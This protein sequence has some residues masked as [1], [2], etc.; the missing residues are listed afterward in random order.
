LSAQIQYALEAAERSG[1]ETRLVEE[2]RNAEPDVAPEVMRILERTSS[3]RVRNAAALALADMRAEGARDSLIEAL[4][5]VETR[6]YR[7]TILYALD[8]L[9]ANLP[10]SVVI[11][12]IVDDPYEAREEAL[13]FLASGRVDSDADPRQVEGK[14]RVA[15]R[16]E[17]EERS[18]ALREALEYLSERAPT[19]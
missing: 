15:L 1:D 16:R 4:R 14:L 9:G 6:G 2:L 18:H 17:D 8:E 11:D 3:P 7:G 13:G 5:R 12:I 10:L 19:P